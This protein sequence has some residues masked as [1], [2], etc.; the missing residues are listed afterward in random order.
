MNIPCPRF[1]LLVA[2]L[3][4]ILFVSCEK[5][6]YQ[7]IEELDEENI[8]NYIQANGLTVQL[9]ENTG[10]YY[11]VMQE[12]TG[13]DIEYTDQVPLVFTQRSLD[14]QYQAIDSLHS[15]NR[16]ADF[17]GYFPFG[18]SYAGQPGSPVEKEE[19]MKMVVKQVLKKA[20][21][22]IRVIV[23]SRQLWGRNGVR[24]RGIPPNASID[25]TI[26]VIDD[27][28]QYDDHQIRNAIVNAGYTV[29]E[30]T[31]NSDGVYY[32]ILSAGSGA[33]VAIDTTINAQYTLRRPDGQIVEENDEFK[34]K[35]NAANV[36]VNAWLTVL[37]NIRRG[38][39]VRLF[40]PSKQAYG[41]SGINSSGI[42]PFLPLDF[43]ITL[44]TE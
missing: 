13:K 19:S 39:K 2:C 43:E 20:G 41:L 37:P 16:Y 1:S 8:R 42:P 30:F 35:L 27:L 10:I 44:N 40:A 11:Q 33:P 25:Y 24:S 5:K 4:A 31:K 28:D 3:S 26:H 15:N 7:T 22:R 21:G 6:E 32:K 12:G 9:F 29:D 34:I 38:G 17:F 36:G 18:S 14:G 23:P